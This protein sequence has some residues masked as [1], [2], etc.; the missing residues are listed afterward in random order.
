VTRRLARIRRARPS[1]AAHI[2]AL[3]AH[4]PSDRMSARSIRR[5]LCAPSV[6]VLI[7]QIGARVV[8]NLVL[9]LR[10]GSR[11]ARVYSVIV[12]PAARGLGVGRALVARAESV[13]RGGG[14]DQVT[15]E[16]RADNAAARR[17][18]AGMG[19]AEVARLRGFYEDGADGLRLAKLLKR[20]RIAR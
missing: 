9:L 6:A 13:A 5:F 1:D 7:A 2:R 4:F 11:N 12:D 14:R 10:K 20:S 8:G 19:Y 3:E 18:Y 17:L 15:L 16:V